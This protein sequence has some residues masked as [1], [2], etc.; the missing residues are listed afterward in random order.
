MVASS[1]DCSIC[2]FADSHLSSCPSKFKC[3][4]VYRDDE[5]SIIYRDVTELLSHVDK[6]L[7][8]HGFFTELSVESSMAIDA[9]CNESLSDQVTPYKPT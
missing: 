8:D 9:V 4:P 7:M 6:V 5:E 3:I 2:H 1:K